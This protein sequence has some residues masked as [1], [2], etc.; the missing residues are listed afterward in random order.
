MI[1]MRG[2]Q[3]QPLSLLLKELAANWASL[4]AAKH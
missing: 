1:G 2:M 3:R 4:A